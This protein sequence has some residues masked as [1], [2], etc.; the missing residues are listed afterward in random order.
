MTDEI[1]VFINIIVFRKCKH[2]KT[3]TYWASPTKIWASAKL[4]K[5]VCG[6]A[7]LPKTL[8]RNICP[9]ACPNV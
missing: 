3:A 1:L 2:S 6:S 7:N 8:A 5:S 9:Q 4:P